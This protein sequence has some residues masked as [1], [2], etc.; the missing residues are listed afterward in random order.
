VIND[1]TESASAAP[2]EPGPLTAPTGSKADKFFTDEMKQRMKDYAVY[3]TVAGV[4]MGIINGIQK[5]IMGAVSPGA[6][7][8]ALFPPF[9][10]DI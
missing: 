9:P 6:Y 1:Y 7:V 5:E 8:S 10:V 2:E 3:S 4:S